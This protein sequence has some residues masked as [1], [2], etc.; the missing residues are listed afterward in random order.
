MTTRNHHAAPNR[1]PDRR[2]KEADMTEPTAAVRLQSQLTQAR[3]LAASGQLQQAESLFA[4][5]LREWPESVE[6]NVGLARCAMDRGDAVRAAQL[7]EVAIRET[8]DDPQLGM[9]LSLA[10]AAAGRHTAARTLLEQ[11]VTRTPDFYLAWLQLGQVREAMGDMVAAG[12]AWFQAT[13][14]AQ[15]QGLWL[16]QQTTQPWLLRTVLDA[17]AKT[18][19]VRRTHF[20]AVYQALKDQ[21]GADA[22]KRVERALTG[23]L[24]EWNATPADPRQRPKFMF[25]PDIP[26]TPYLDPYLQPWAPALAAAFPLIRAE[27]ERLLAEDHPFQNFLDFSEGVPVENYLS[28]D[29]PKPAW[30]AFF[31]YRHGQRF[32]D[33]HAR[34]PHTSAV[35][36][37]L[38]L[39]RIKGQAPEICFSLLTPG[40][41]IMPHHGVTNSRVVV[42]LPLIVPGDCALNIVDGEAHYWQEGRLMMFDDTFQHE[43]WN[44][45]SRTRVIL[46]MDAWNPHLTDVEKLAMKQL[47][48]TISDFDPQQQV[49]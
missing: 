4:T 1:R 9:N 23:Y 26:C 12:K 33:N 47:V 6:A 3:Q 45:S 49:T 28:G 46:L 43:A 40:S 32:D 11:V 37:S 21:H 5:V 44:R 41:H 30:D 18:R 25:F 17:I 13:N 42:H 16:N 39:C 2:T 20:I 15:K 29:G 7:L 14:R 10:Y 48:E 34:C 8:P 35:L 38:E 19:S 22:L 36:E 27:A 24:G 31:F